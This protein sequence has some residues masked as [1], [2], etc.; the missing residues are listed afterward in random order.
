[1]NLP[2]HHNPDQ[3]RFECR[4]QGGLAL[5]QYRRRDGGVDFIHTEVPEALSGQGVAAALVKQALEWARG[6]GL[7]VRPL[8]SYVASYMRRHPETQDLLE[9]G[10]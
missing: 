10:A 7:T 8:C 1:M 2:V 4:L 9:R 6:E 5:C 3:N